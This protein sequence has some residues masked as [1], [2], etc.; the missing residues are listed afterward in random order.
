MERSIAKLTEV[1]AALEAGIKQLDKAL[2]EA[3][4]QKKEENADCKELTV[5]SKNAKEVLLWD[6]KFLLELEKGCSTKTQFKKC[7]Q[8]LEQAPW[9]SKRVLQA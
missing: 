2:V 1:I 3:P 4:E 7:C 6:E 5:N 9:R 8:V